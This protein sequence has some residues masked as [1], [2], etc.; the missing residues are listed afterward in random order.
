M[1]KIGD[2]NAIAYKVGDSD[3][4]IYLGEIKMYP[5]FE[6][7][8]LI[9]Y[10][11]STTYSADCDATS[12]ITVSELNGHTTNMTKIFI[13]NCVTELESGLFMDVQSLSSV[14]IPSTVDTI[15]ASAF[16]NCGITTLSIPRA[17]T[18][19]SD[20]LCYGSSL[21]KFKI[22]N[23]VTSIGTN[24]FANCMSLSSVT[25]P[26]SVT[27]MGIAAFSGDTNLSTLS[28]GSGITNISY[29]AF[30]YCSGLT[31][32]EI[33]STVET[34]DEGAFAS[35][36]GLTSIEIPDSVTIISGGSFAFCSSATTLTIG[37]GVTAIGDGAFYGCTNLTKITINATTP[38][39][40]GTYA[41]D[42]TNNC[43]IKVPNA[44][45]EA[46]KTAWS[47]YASRIVDA[48]PT[49]EY[50]RSENTTTYYTVNTGFYPTTANTIEVKM[51]MVDM[52]VDWGMILG[53]SSGNC[54]NCDATQFRFSTV[55][56]GYQIIA[57]GGNTG[58]ISY[59]PTIGANIPIVVKLPISATSG[60]Y[61][62]GQGDV[63]L[64]YNYNDSTWYNNLPSPT[65][66]H[67]FGIGY[68]KYGFVGKIYYVKIYDE[69]NNVVKHYLP[70][71]D[72]GTPCFYEA[73]N[74][75]F[76]YN[77]GVGTLTLGN[78][79]Q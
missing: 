45:I 43:P 36:S 37:G 74:G 50:I 38:P 4:S 13:G 12:A 23:G 14:T 39:T 79:I 32:I 15:G 69:N 52:S 46:Y 75:E 78:E 49:Y 1:L 34:I 60:T 63:T 9:N 18:T 53:W 20:Y 73:I 48:P 22:S 35:C 76:I 29:E 8:Y 33:P 17:V 68:Q 71:S 25:I 11:D 56:N 6:G 10:S 62:I 2:L 55:T 27:T 67:L 59:R 24:A 26:D 19:L 7:K 65:P 30:K 41:L 51:E 77:T 61:N 54:D 57:R 64:N 31:E 5:L 28:I 70:S 72:D 58:G 3:C 66:L 40:L 44:S 21:Q 42:D 16:T 47:Q